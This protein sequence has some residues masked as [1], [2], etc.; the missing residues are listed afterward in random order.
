MEKFGR[1]RIPHIHLTVEDVKLAHSRFSV[2]LDAEL[3]PEIL[4][5]NTR[6]SDR[7]PLRRR[8][9]DRPD[10]AVG[11]RDVEG[12]F[13]RELDRSTHHEIG[14]VGKTHVEG[15]VD[16]VV[17]PRAEA[18]IILR[19]AP[20]F[21]YGRGLIDEQ[22]N[23]AVFAARPLGL[24]FGQARPRLPQQRQT[25][26]RRDSPGEN[27]VKRGF[28]QAL[29]HRNDFRSC[30]SKVAKPL[31][32]RREEAET[33]PRPG[34]ALEE[35][36][37]PREVG[38]RKLTIKISGEQLMIGRRHVKRASSRSTHSASSCRMRQSN[39]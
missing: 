17:V 39:W 37:E 9:H 27:S 12:I 14:P 34:A 7:E 10:I 36:F 16:E 22:G 30:R 19:A 25:G 5:I 24:N 8:G 28:R 3:G 1:F 4:V 23:P 31:G 33:F 32:Y 11:D 15:A 26:R 21:K 13:Y 18:D 2:D 29:P 20:L 35:R 6:R 38:L